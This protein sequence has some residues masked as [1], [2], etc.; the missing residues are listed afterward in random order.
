SGLPLAGIVAKAEFMSWEPG[1]H[2]STFGGNP[3]ACAAALG[4]IA[5]I[6]A[7][8]LVGRAR[9][10]GKVMLTRLRD[11]AERTPAIGDVRGRG[12]MVA[13]ELVDPAT[14]APDPVATKAAAAACHAEGLV[15]L[16]A[17]TDGNVLRFLPPLVIPDHLLQEGLDIVEKALCR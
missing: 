4:A 3:V 2:G 9:H 13:V 11:M 12:A 5:T 15:V 14:G 10:I 1:G 8:D 17:G 16:T 7:E 6:E